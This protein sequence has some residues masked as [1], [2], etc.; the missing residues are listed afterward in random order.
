MHKSHN[1]FELFGAAVLYRAPS[2]GLPFYW[3]LEFV[4]QLKS[5]HLVSSEVDRILDLYC[6]HIT[7]LS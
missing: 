2:Q 1:L 7:K 4:V 6:S 3:N 5:V